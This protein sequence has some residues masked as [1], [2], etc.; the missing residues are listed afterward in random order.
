MNDEK[1]FEDALVDYKQQ[2][3]PY[4]FLIQSRE[5]RCVE[6]KLF[7]ISNVYNPLPLANFHKFCF[8][9]IS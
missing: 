3:K 5:K 2:V 9:L 4:F 1:S 7:R 8:V 6:V